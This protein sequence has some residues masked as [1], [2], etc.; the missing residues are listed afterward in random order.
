M[1]QADFSTIKIGVEYIENTNVAKSLR[2]IASALQ[3]LDTA[4]KSLQSIKDVASALTDLGKVSLDSLANQLSS[5]VNSLKEIRNIGT[6]NVSTELQ[7]TNQPINDFLNSIDTLGKQTS[8]TVR[9]LKNGFK[10]VKVS[11][12]SETKEAEKSVNHFGKSFGNFYKKTIGNFFKSIRRI[13]FYRI[14]RYIVQSIQKAIGEGFNNIVLYSDK[15]NEALTNIKANTKQF[16]NQ[17]ASA[18]GNIITYFAPAI[19]VLQNTILKLTDTMTQFFAAMNGDNTYLKA[20]KNIEDYR[21]SLQKLKSVGIDELNVLESDTTDTKDLYT[22]EQVDLSKELT[23]N[24][25][26]FG[27]ALMEI[28]SILT[29]IL[30]EIGKVV[31]RLL[32]A[33]TKIAHLINRI[34]TPLLPV[35]DMIAELVETIVD[36]VLKLIE[37]VVNDMPELCELLKVAFGFLNMIVGV[38]SKIKDWADEIGKGIGGI[39]DDFVNEFPILQ[40][41]TNNVRDFGTEIKNFVKKA[42]ELYENSMVKQIFDWFDSI[43]E[44]LKSFFGNN[45][46]GKSVADWL[47]NIFNTIGSWFGK[48]TNANASGY[49]Y[50][51][52]GFVDSGQLFVARESGAELVGTMSGRTAVANNDQIV[53]GIYRGVLQ[54]MNDSNSSGTNV[55]VYLDSNE[56]NDT[57]VKKQKQVGIGNSLYR[58]GSLNGI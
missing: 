23:Q 15:V 24:A 25:V 47:K 6:T 4:S 49:Y 12:K 14:I 33:I 51:N 22:E 1:A 18:I 27:S 17:F 31:V 11:V 45:G 21:A 20:K 16:Y 30:D 43:T 46:V 8:I 48:N 58:G 50:A 35:I 5:F 32:P 9:D 36:L 57:I 42:G 39:F 29:P 10:S 53:E 34:I 41:I 52:G 38:L 37:P 56:I 3:R 40:E 2:D 44:K 55:V 26:E 28:V 54:A 19:E 13:A 7:Q